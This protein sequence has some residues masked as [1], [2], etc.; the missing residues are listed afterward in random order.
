[1]KF[2]F[3]KNIPVNITDDV[4]LWD[5]K[6][7]YDHF[8][9]GSLENIDVTKLTGRILAKTSES[10]IEQIFLLPRVKGVSYIK[11]IT[12]LV[13]DIESI[14]SYVYSTFKIIK[15][16]GGI[17]KKDDGSLLMVYR[18]GKWELPKGKLEEGEDFS[19]AALR[20]VKEE[21]GVVADLSDEV[22]TTWYSYVIKGKIFFKSVKWY[23]MNNVD[24][25]CMKPQFE[26]GITK[27]AWI[28]SDSIPKVLSHSYLSIR[29]IFD[30]YFKL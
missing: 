12:L 16:A 5:E 30:T 8:I 11:K 26:E 18:M 29:Y 21:C 6:E 2:F 1:M 19:T 23:K 3:T 25:S 4:S 27:V 13:D 20:E 17:V 14:L 10:N 7:L 28:S 9:E 24:D 22:C 15:A